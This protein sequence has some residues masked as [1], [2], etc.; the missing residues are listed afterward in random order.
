MSDKILQ[1]K[2]YKKIIG[3]DKSEKVLNTETKKIQ[4]INKIQQQNLKSIESIKG[5]IKLK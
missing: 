3:F 2:I 4:N 1:K 5:L